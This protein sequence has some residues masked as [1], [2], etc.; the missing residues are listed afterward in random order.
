MRRTFFLT[1]GALAL[2]ALS[3]VC[4]Q[5]GIGF[6][7]VL[8]PAVG[9]LGL[10]H[11][12]AEYGRVSLGGRIE[13]RGLRYASPDGG[14]GLKIAELKARIAPLSL[15]S[16][17]LVH[18]DSVVADGLQ[19]E[20]KPDGAADATSANGP[21]TDV[22]TTVASAAD[23]PGDP[24]AVLES[25][26]TLP[27]SIGRFRINA[28]RLTA[29]DSGGETTR[30]GPAT[31]SGEAFTP[32]NRAKL[33][34]DGPWSTSIDAAAEPSV[35]FPASAAPAPRKGRLE[36]RSEFEFDPLGVLMKWSLGLK[37]TSTEPGK[38]ATVL[39]LEGEGAH[40]QDDKI[41]ARLSIAAGKEGAPPGRI[42][43]EVEVRGFSDT[44]SIED[45]DATARFDLL[46]LDL[47]SLNDFLPGGMG[48]DIERGTVAGHISLVA[49]DR[50]P[51][52]AEAELSLRSLALRLPGL[53]VSDG[54]LFFAGTLHPNEKSL[55]VRSLKLGLDLDGKRRISANLN[56]PLSLDLNRKASTPANGTAARPDAKAKFDLLL[57]GLPLRALA[58][59]VLESP[60]NLQS[61]TL[62]G[63]LS[64]TI[65]AGGQNIE[66]K[67]SARSTD[68]RILEDGRG[69]ALPNL[70]TELSF[71]IAELDKMTLTQARIQQS[72]GEILVKGTV[73][74]TSPAGTGPRYDLS[75]TTHHFALRPWLD[76]LLLDPGSDAGP[77]PLEGK[78]T[79]RHHSSG[80]VLLDGNPTIVLGLPKGGKQ[81]VALQLKGRFEE[82][83]EKRLDATLSAPGKP[84]KVAL[85]LRTET[86]DRDGRA[87]LKV[88]ASASDLELLP[89]LALFGV[90]SEPW[91]G[92]LTLFGKTE[93]GVSI[94]GA[95]EL[96]ANQSLTFLLP[97][98][99]GSAVLALDAKGTLA[100]SGALSIALQARRPTA[101]GA[102]DLK[103]TRQPAGAASGREHLSAKATIENL[104]LTPWLRPFIDPHRATPPVAPAP[105]GASTPRPGKP[106]SGA[107]DLALAAA[108]P[109]QSPAPAANPRAAGPTSRA[110]V[111]PSS[112]NADLELT[113]EIRSSRYR[114]VEIGSLK[115]DLTRRAGSTTGKLESS[116]LAGGK[117]H[118][119]LTF[120]TDADDPMRFSGDAKDVR[121]K[122]VMDA[123][124][125]QR[126]IDGSLDFNAEGT[127]DSSRG[128]A[129]IDGLDASLRF[130]VSQGRMEGFEVLSVLAD[131]TG[132]EAFAE[133]SFSSFGGDL[134]VRDGTLE[135]KKADAGGSLTNVKAGGTVDLRRPGAWDLTLTPHVGPSLS[136]RLGRPALL[137]GLLESTEGFFALPVVVRVSGPLGEPLF[138]VRTASP[139]NV[140][141]DHG[142]RVVT[143]LLDTISGGLIG[144]ALSGIGD[145]L[146][147]AST[148]Q[149]IKPRAT[150]AP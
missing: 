37:A 69:I 49:K 82:R 112:P 93:L 41:N 72:Q 23:A 138:S 98:D 1:L 35:E 115:A 44:R 65:A 116:G 76:A 29:V 60:E 79:L 113:L 80:A 55:Q 111:K 127:S 5:T 139:Q 51:F 42:K 102:L 84:G 90:E 18:I 34:F 46:E 17:A 40:A 4:L 9:A 86:T 99:Q 101:S 68:V 47:G 78:L 103:L 3:V 61:G 123:F 32:A 95:V 31:L 20:T 14:L 125:G 136:R 126:R 13:A 135:I 94:D 16:G 6:R 105:P 100:K 143:D 74:R 130:D 110:L 133:L 96:Q 57:S 10:G 50:A 147:G 77:L 106:P 19:V 141:A 109:V 66:A 92:P 12:E 11:L 107:A 52:S 87:P 122:P 81:V 54:Q 144:R 8:A 140:I 27:F 91:A 25:T 15:V 142:G 124:A 28:L 131:A 70:S 73:D 7:W 58:P 88:E 2:G 38:T 67:G 117:L 33:A 149:P 30:V 97:G 43:G 119:G 56:E 83:G 48:P 137:G 121:L 108:R 118:A 45:L 63:T 36:L 59:L 71:E 26:L 148:P 62:D 64:M 89:W 145:G 21:D 129:L 39:D 132:V 114:E 150:P 134:E 24:A 128:N 22:P 120:G 104:D 53:P 85:L 146:F 75:L